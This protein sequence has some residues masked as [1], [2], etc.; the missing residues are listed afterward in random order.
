V[1]SDQPNGLLAAYQWLGQLGYRV[2]RETDGSL[3]LDHLQ[4]GHD[5]LIIISPQATFSGSLRQRVLSWVR[6]GGRLVVATDGSTGESLLSAAGVL[7]SQTFPVTVGV[8]EPLLLSPPVATLSGMTD[9]VAQAPP[10]GVA[11]APTSSGAELVRLPVGRGVV[12]VLTAPT[13]FDNAAIRQGDNRA[14]LLNVTGRPPA[15]VGFDEYAVP[16]G[17]APSVP[18]DWLTQSTWGVAVLFT[19]LLLALYRWLSG[20]RLGPP[21]IPLSERHRPLAEYVVSMGGLLQR[22]KERKGV[23]RMYQ[24]TLGRELRTRF[25]PDYQDVLDAE[26]QDRVERLLAVPDQLAEEELMRRAAEIVQ[27]E[28]DLRKVRV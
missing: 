26:T 25:G 11:V 22:G 12:W 8:H 27:C 20:W 17:S 18:T 19:V 23:L 10:E 9:V 13:L 28:D 24:D 5:T 14:L 1:T 2:E 16:A 6:S 4:A 7:L 3:G 21:V 15:R